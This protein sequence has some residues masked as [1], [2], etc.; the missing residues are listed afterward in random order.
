MPAD[1]TNQLSHSAARKLPTRVSLAK[2]VSPS[3]PAP[4]PSTA[5]PQ[6]P[7]VPPERW[8][9]FEE[10]L[11]AHLMREDDFFPAERTRCGRLPN[12]ADLRL[13]PH[14]NSRPAD[15]LFCLRCLPPRRV[16]FRVPV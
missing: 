8:V 9:V 3:L 5:C 6:L 14:F 4:P 11:V 7:A 1:I 15:Y 12:D 10:G 16:S 2:V 13:L